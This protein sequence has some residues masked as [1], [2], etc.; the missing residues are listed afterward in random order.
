[1]SSGTRHQCMI[2]DGSPSRMLPALVATIRQRLDARARCM[3]INS[4]SMVAGLRSQLYAAGTDVESE[5]ARGSLVLV[6][7]NS[8]LVDGR[9]EVNRMIDL[10]VAA[11]QSALADG[12]AGL[13]ATGD[14]TWEFGPEKRF[15][16]L[17]EYE[18]RLEQVFREQPA[19]S[20]ICQY[21]RDLLPREAV[22]EGVVSHASVFI[23]DTLS[24]LNPLYV[25]APGERTAAA[26]T[27]LD[28]AI[29]VLL[30]AE[31]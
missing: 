12:Y 10:L 24:R 6:S 20:G 14:M 31:A 26:T 21:H 27:A 30:A 13:F 1:M 9:F 15:S 2:Y 19:L 28:D 11:V 8:H 23:N 25:S 17:L 7:D 16:K 22:R 5:L 29:P 18:C 3:Y 4:P